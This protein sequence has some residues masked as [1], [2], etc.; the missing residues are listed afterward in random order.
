MLPLFPFARLRENAGWHFDDRVVIP[1]SRPFPTRTEIPMSFKA[2]THWKV[3]YPVLAGMKQCVLS[4]IEVA[5]RYSVLAL[6]AT[7]VGGESCNQVDHHPLLKKGN[8][9]TMV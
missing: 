2:M 8:T 1:E 6:L 4:L 5:P 9:V 3:L 7:T